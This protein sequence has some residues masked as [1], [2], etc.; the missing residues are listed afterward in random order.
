MAVNPSWQ[1]LPHQD[2]AGRDYG[3]PRAYALPQ[4]IAALVRETAQNSL[5]A[6]AGSGLVAMRFRLIDLPSGCAR[7]KKFEK[8]IGL[9]SLRS[10]LQAVVDAKKPKEVADRLRAAL[11]SLDDTTTTLRLLIVEDYGARGLQGDEFEGDS[12]FAAL[13]RNT[14]DS[15]KTNEAAG[16]SFGLGSGTLWACSQYLT[17]IFA[18][19]LA[20]H[21]ESKIRVFGKSG[22]GYHE[23]DS[24]SF[25]GPGFFGTE[26]RKNVAVSYWA[27]PDDN[28]LADLCLTRNP[29]EGVAETGTSALIVA[30]EEPNSDDDNSAEILASLKTEIAENLW[31]A[32]VKKSL[33]VCVRHE[34]GDSYKSAVDEVIDPMLFVPSFVQAFERHLANDVAESLSNPG[35]VVS[36]PVPHI[37][38]GTRPDADTDIKHTETQSEARLV[39]RLASGD[40]PDSKRIDQVALARGR[41]MVVQYQAR[42]SVGLNAR[43]F[44]AVLLAGTM[45][46]TSEDA[47]IAERFFRNAEPPAH[48]CW[49]F[50]T[51]VKSLYQHGAK[52]L[53]SDFFEG[54][55]RALKS[56][57][58]APSDGSDDGPE[59][60][61]SLV[62]IPTQVTAEKSTWRLKS[63]ATQT[64]AG[65]VKFEFI[66]EVDKPSGKTFSPSVALGTESGGAMEMEIVD[67]DFDGSARPVGVPISLD[68]SKQRYRVT[69]HARPRSP[70]L[71]LARCAVRI[72]GIVKKV[73]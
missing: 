30:F 58:V 66:L 47:E 25:T 53:L 24:K 12:N 10:H 23:V 52:K 56:A 40:E 20:G 29:I 54:V 61:R 3:D 46:G 62:T 17:V 72:S 55:S 33:K 32:I 31:P 35:D 49:K 13:L 39:I 36:I 7:R 64:Q 50:W 69:G 22:L 60:L 16:G 6:S 34:I 41:A 1:W 11:E 21:D 65:S 71:N 68:G 70:G 28:V 44:H 38:P 42:R 57:V 45:V 43:P 15:Q 26:K 19:V 59:G 51:R 73:S 2:G 5:D 4:S 48:D 8:R 67:L 27:T 9:V 18:S 63:V 14:R 37:V